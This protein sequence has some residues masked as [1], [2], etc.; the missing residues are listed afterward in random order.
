MLT[1][2]A[3]VWRNDRVYDIKINNRNRFVLQAPSGDQVADGQRFSITDD[4][5]GTVHFEFDSGYRV[6]LP[7]AFV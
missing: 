7:T 4:Q 6:Q 5:G 2:L 1:P 3:G